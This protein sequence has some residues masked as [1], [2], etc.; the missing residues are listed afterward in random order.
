MSNNKN[1]RSVADNARRETKLLAKPSKLTLDPFGKTDVEL[2][3]PFP[4]ELGEYAVV[5][6]ATPMTTVQFT[7]A[8]PVGIT[9][10][11]E[12]SW[13][14]HRSD[15]LQ[16]M[17]ARAKDPNQ[18]QLDQ[19]RTATRQRLAVQHKLLIEKEVDGRK[20]FYYPHRGD[21]D[22]NRL[23]EGARVALK[24]V[25]S[26]IKARIAALTD[27]NKH[28]KQGLLNR[29]QH[30]EDPLKHLDVETSVAEEKLREFYKS[31]LVLQVVLEENPQKYRTLS[32]PYFTVPQ[33]KIPGSENL[34]LEDVAIRFARSVASGT[35]TPVP[36]K[37]QQVSPNKAV[38]TEEL[39]AGG[40]VRRY[41]EQSTPPSGVGDYSPPKKEEEVD[42]GTGKTTFR[43]VLQSVTKKKGATTG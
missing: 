21:M 1:Q 41:S 3:Q 23:L 31:P 29:L 13:V 19:A 42:P 37:E 16:G 12:T 39:E 6:I 34:R 24:E 15:Q 14:A 32:G 9:D 17:L 2:K 38:N 40:I 26:E 36:K 35:A 30:A 20:V 4:K 7:I 10:L 43:S 11:D 22:R 33:T 25:T 27:E 8:H 28:E 5:V 18:A